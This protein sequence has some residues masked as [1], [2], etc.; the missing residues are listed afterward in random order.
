VRPD[1][2]SHTA[3][4]VASWRALEA[5]LP[6][7]G[8][9]VSD[10]HARAFLGPGRGRVLDLVERLPGRARAALARRADRFLQGSMS[11]V[12]ARHRA[13]DDLLAA[14]A[15]EQEQV[16]LLGAGYDSR[17]VRLAA[18]LGEVPL[19]EVDHPATAGRKE[20]LAGA[21]F[22]GRP[23]ARTVP[24]TVDFQRE[25]I[26]ERLAAAGFEGGRLTTWVW[27]G[28]TMYL[29]AEAVAETLDMVRRLSAPGSLLACDVWSRPAAGRLQQLTTRDLPA[30]ALRLV[31]DEP[32]TWGPPAEALDGLFRD[33]GLALIEETPRP[34]LVAR[35][36]PRRAR[37]L[38]RLETGLLLCVA[39]VERG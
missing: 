11:F 33:R 39:E 10:P 26:E 37:S 4:M 7:D 13:I 23:R 21:A 1:R 16:V 36:Q 9:I 17:S 12:L 34:E 22:A 2:P 35:Y 5:L 24:V 3:E 38:G 32:L 19:F 18:P 31:Y 6:A 27:E 25:S 20:A 29:D 14:R 28:V 15:G 8:R 30:L